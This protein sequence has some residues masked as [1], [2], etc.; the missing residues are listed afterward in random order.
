GCSGGVHHGYGSSTDNHGSRP[1]GSARKRLRGVPNS[2]ARTRQGTEQVRRDGSGSGCL[3]GALLLHRGPCR[4]NR[5]ITPRFRGSCKCQVSSSR[6]SERRFLRSGDA[7]EEPALE[8][9]QTE[10]IV[11]PCERGATCRDRKSTRLNSSHVAISY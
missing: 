4:S 10:W 9:G 8:P 2:P 1:L 3:C 11:P 5:A 7:Y 6:S